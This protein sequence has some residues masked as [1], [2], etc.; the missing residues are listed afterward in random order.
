[1][2]E[3]SIG[4]EYFWKKSNSWTWFDGK[5]RW[6]EVFITVDGLNGAGGYWITERW[7]QRGPWGLSEVMREQPRTLSLKESDAL[8]QEIA[9]ASPELFAGEADRA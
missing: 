5:D 4:H 8:A 7:R 3:L 2:P 1:M 9:T 6:W